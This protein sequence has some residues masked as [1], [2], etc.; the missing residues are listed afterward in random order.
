[1]QPSCPHSPALQPAFPEAR[2]TDAA[3]AGGIKDVA[4][5]A[6]TGK[7]ATSIGALPIVA[8]AALLALIHIWQGGEG[9]RMAGGPARRGFTPHIPPLSKAPCSLSGAFEGEAPPPQQSIQR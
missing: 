6:D 1:M 5:V 9:D 7:A 4:L 2:L 3:A 8:E